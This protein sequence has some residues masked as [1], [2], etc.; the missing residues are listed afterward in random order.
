MGKC[1]GANSRFT[2]DLIAQ[3]WRRLGKNATGGT[4][5]VGVPY[6]HSLDTTMDGK[7]FIV[8][9]TANLSAAFGVAREAKNDGTVVDM[10]T[11]GMLNAYV[12]GHTDLSMGD[13]LITVNTKTYFGYGAASDGYPA[14]AIMATAYTNTTVATLKS[15]MLGNLNL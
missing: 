10:Y 7:S 4:T 15:I 12:I 6:C 2:T 3:Q 5:S 13:K 9:A 14:F 1:V 8:A 11:A